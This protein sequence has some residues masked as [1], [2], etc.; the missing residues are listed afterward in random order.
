MIYNLVEK[1]LAYALQK[2]LITEDEITWARNTLLFAL[3]LEKQEK[4]SLYKGKIPSCPAEILQAISTWAGKN[5]LLPADTRTYRDNFETYLMSLFTLRPQEINEKFFNLYK[6]NPKKA[7]DF[8]YQYFKDN[9]YIRTDRI[10]KNIVWK[11]KTKSGVL[12]MAINL[13]KPEKDPKEITLQ[14][15]QPKNSAALPKCMLCKENEGFFGAIN[16]PSKQNLRLIKLNLNGEIFYFQYSP[17]SYYNEHSIVFSK[18]HYLMEINAKTLKNLLEFAEKF[19]HYFIGSNAE[20]PIVGGSILTHNHYQAGCHSFA[21]DKAKA[22]FNFKLKK[23]PKVKAQIIKWP[24]NTIRLIGS[25]EQVFAAGTHIL[26]AWRNYT[27]KEANLICKTGKTQHSTITPIARRKN[28]DFVLDLILRNNKDALFHTHKERQN[29]KKENIGLIEALG[30]AVLPGRLEREFAQIAQILKK[31]DVERL[32]DLSSTAQHYNWVKSF[33][34][35]YPNYHKNPEEILLKETAL[36][37]EKMLEDCA[38]FK[39][40]EQGK[41]AFKRFINTF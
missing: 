16:Y 24:M 1:L 37:F 11:Q 34:N 20:L 30:L 41:K 33:I 2:E 7:T 39:D 15:Q 26:N 12:E 36:T 8:L 32:Q 5:N 25:K 6:K 17:Y 18:E 40:T 38:V 35:K 13:S 3:H 9:Y 10:A 27:D 29:I 21:L 22:L 23:Y 14:I 31:K 4:P 28:K 19:P